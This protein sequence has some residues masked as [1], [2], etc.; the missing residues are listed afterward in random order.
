MIEELPRWSARMNLT[1]EFSEYTD[2]SAVLA[3]HYRIFSAL[4]SYLG[5]YNSRHRADQIYLAPTK[6]ALKGCIKQRGMNDASYYALLNAVT[7]FCEETKGLRALPTPHP[8]TVHSIQLP[9][10]AF[11]IIK[12]SVGEY[13]LKIPDCDPVYFSCAKIPDPI[14]FIILRPKM[15]RAGTPCFSTWEVLLFKQNHGYIVNWTD[16]SINPRYAGMR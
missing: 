11:E 7:R 6:E 5:P 2:L 12:I 16:S 14:K 4:E 10:S 9:E 1:R 13:V 8:C 3:H 15:G